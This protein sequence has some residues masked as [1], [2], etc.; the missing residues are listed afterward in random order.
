MAASLSGSPANAAPGNGLPEMT[1]GKVRVPLPIIQGGM[2]VGVSGARLAGAVSALG[3]LGTLSSAC[4][5]SVVGTRLGRKLSTREAMAEEVRAAK[6][7]SN[8]PVA[9]NIMVALSATYGDSVLG[10]MDGGV[11]VIISGAGLPLNLP[12]IVA[13][14]PRSGEV[15]LVPIVSSGRA[16]Q[17]IIKRWSKSGRLPSAMIVEGPSAGGHLGWRTVAE[18]EDPDNSLENLLAEVL[19]VSKANGKFPVIA[20]GGIYHKADITRMLELGAAGVQIGTRFLATEES[21]ATP[22][23]KQAVVACGPDDI[24]V[25]VTPGSPCQLPFRVLN[26]CGMFVES[27]E[28]KRKAKCDKHYLLRDGKCLAKDDP[29]SYFCICN[30]LLCAAGIGGMG[31]KPLYTVGSNAA[32]VDRIMTVAELMAEL[33]G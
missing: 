5:D 31:E 17:L 24:V 16:A 9:V 6:A 4:I 3:G 11:D 28:G 12:A 13:S 8:V 21:G 15:E 32:R 1:I 14:H 19:E 30:G 20:A 29:N 27:V 7:G 18:I 25:A 2:G 10:A 22:E 23:F 33:A 26:T